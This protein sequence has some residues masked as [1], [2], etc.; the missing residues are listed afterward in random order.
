MKSYLKHLSRLS[1]TL[2]LIIST[3]LSFQSIAFAEDTYSDVRDSAARLA[4]VIVNEYGVSGI[5]YALISDGETVLSGTSGI[6]NI[7][8]TKSLDENS[9]FGIGSI[10]KM[11]PSTAIMILSDQ[12][13]I[14]LDKPVTAYIPEFKMAD[15]RYKE[16]TV[17]MLLNHSSGLMGSNYNNSFLYDYR[18]AFGH[19][20]LLRQ[21]ANEQ[22]KAAPGEFSVYCNDGFTLAEIVVERVSGLSFSEFIRKNITEPLGMNNTYT[23]LDDFD[24]GRMAR[25]FVNG[26]ETPADTGSIIGAGGIYSTAEDL[27]RFGQAYMSSP[28]FL[29]AAGLLSPDAKAMTMQKEYK[30]GFGPDQMEGLFGY[31]L[32]WDSVDAFPYSQYNIQSLIKGGD[33]Q[34]Y[35]GSMIVLPEYNMVFAALMSGGSSLFGQ[36][37]GQTLLLETLLAENEIEEIIPPKQLQAPVLSALPPELTSYSGIYISSTEMLKINVGADGKTVVTSISDKS[38]PNEIYYYTAEGVFVNE[39][40]SKQFSFADESNGKTYINLKRI[41]NLPDLG[42]TVSTLYQYEKTEPNIIDDKV[43]DTWDARAGS[44][45]YIVNEHPYSQFYHRSESTY[46]EI[47]ANKEL[48]GYTV[49]FKIVDDKR[50]VQDVQIPG[51]DGR[52]LVTIEILS[53]SGK[54]YLKSDNCI[55]ISEKDI[56]DIYAG[57]AYCTIQE[58]GYARWYT[59]NRKDAGKTMTVSLPKNGSFAVYDEKSC[60]YFSVVNG[61]RPVVLPENGKVV[62]I[63]EKPGDRFYITADFAGNRGEALYRQALSSENERELSR[64]AELYKSA[65]PLLRDSGNSLAFDCS[66]ALQRI[67]II[68]GIYPYTKEAVK[69]L[70]IQT[71]PQVTEAAVNSWI[72]SKEL[73]TYYYDGEEY[74]FE[75]AAA[76]LIYRHLDLM[77]ADAARQEA[78]YNLVLE[79]NKLAEEEPENTWQQYQKPVTYRGTHTI[80]IPRQ[81]LPESGTY[82]I[83]IPVPIVGGPQ[84]QVTIDYVTP[85]KWVKQPPSINDDIGLLYLEIPMEELSEDLFIQVKF[86]FAHYEQR[87]TVDPQN[88]GDY[89]KDSYLYKEYT[90]SYGNTEITPEIQ[91]KALEI[92]G[93]ETNPFFAARRI[94]DYIV[95]NIDY[96]FMPH[97][98][99]WPRTA[100]AESVYVH[101]NLRGDCGAQSMYFTALCRSVGIPARSTGGY[102]LISGDFGDHFW[103]EFY[104]PNYGWVP[105]DTS[106]AQTA[107][108]SEDASSE[109]RQSYIDYYFGNQDSMRCVI[110]RDTDETLIPKANGMVL[111]P[112]AI[113][114]PAAE[115]SIP[116]GDIED[117]FVNHWTMTLEK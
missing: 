110:Q 24:R 5:Q 6:F 3:V 114:F 87:F 34:L 97:M 106:A 59:V 85:L 83:W 38:Q 40:G 89:D 104:L 22:L 18:S 69:E 43:Q 54:E 28:G 10:S 52:D 107:F 51:L 95:N 102:Q 68:Q 75:D 67:A 25:T 78:Y 36:V 80:S 12:G 4:D 74:Y 30:R 91:S 99:L 98:A 21:L 55:Y 48:P 14:D 17:R 60:I 64:A 33:T 15:P 93:A 109:Q 16:I 92:V 29:P 77:Y 113:Q 32:G 108:Y 112:L 1:V 19:D 101:E 63:G 62:F 79:I 82:R 65:L 23:P 49:Q 81:E 56:V 66:E 9:I 47:A 70:I 57:N 26:E 39:N 31:G 20:N 41:Y 72:E 76:N 2:L 117:I 42:Q 94:Y 7:D 37:M 13:K 96:S 115:Y 61:N 73:E 90:K 86:S 111:A 71:Y 46:F 27:C 50:A 45:Y 58:D 105:V 103:A 100:Q 88:I 116:T 53:E 8:N 84:T 11:F 44:K 35:H